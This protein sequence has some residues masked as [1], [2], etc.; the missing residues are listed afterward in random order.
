MIRFANEIVV[1]EESEGNIQCA[2]G[3]INEIFRT[4]EMKMN[5]G[6]TMIL[7][8]ARDPKIKADV[9]IDSQKLEQLEEMVYLRSKIT[10]DGKSV[11][12]TKQHIVLANTAF[13]K[14]HKLLT[15]KK[16]C[17]VMLTQHKIIN[18]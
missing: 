18:A 16:L 11:R 17:D 7:V 2:V 4:S 10:F 15:S 5:S 1:I 12:E 13:S 14:I 9:Y 8:C 3:K 6:K